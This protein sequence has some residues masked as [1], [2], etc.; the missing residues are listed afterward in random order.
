MA[1]ESI[2]LPRDFRDLLVQPLPE[3]GAWPIYVWNIIA[4]SPFEAS[5]DDKCWSLRET[6][7]LLGSTKVTF[8]INSLRFHYFTYLLSPFFRSDFFHSKNTFLKKCT[9]VVLCE[10]GSES[11]E[12]SSTAQVIPPLSAPLTCLCLA[13][14]GKTCVCLFPFHVATLQGVHQQ[15][16]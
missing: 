13:F 14:G 6:A 9:Q 3:G 16:S 5:Q 15:L 11:F 12:V 7:P 8:F 1:Q 4:Q 10:T 2:V